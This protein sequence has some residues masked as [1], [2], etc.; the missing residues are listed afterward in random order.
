[1]NPNFNI[2]MYKLLNEWNP[3][4]LENPTQGDMEF[5]EIMDIIHQKLPVEE[6]IERIQD[7]FMHSFEQSPD[8]S[9]IMSLLNKIYQ[10][11]ATCEIV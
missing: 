1:M 10:L 9:E 6:T 2:A 3:M 7:V 5:Y 4:Q 11:R 8:H